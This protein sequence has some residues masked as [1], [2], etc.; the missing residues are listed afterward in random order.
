MRLDNASAA[1]QTANQPKI[2]MLLL[3]LLM[4]IAEVAG[5]NYERFNKRIFFANPDVFRRN[6]VSSIGQ[7]LI[8]SAGDSINRSF[9][10]LTA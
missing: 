7:N 1:H 3:M 4:T 8:R 2:T 10:S 9:F 5:A 6:T